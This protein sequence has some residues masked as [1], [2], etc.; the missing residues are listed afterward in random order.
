MKKLSFLGIALL[1]VVMLV[2]SCKKDENSGPPTINF[3]GGEGYIDTDQVIETGTTFKVGIAASANIESN[4]KLSTLRVTRSM[5]GST[6]IDTTLTINET[7]YNVDFEFNSQQAGVVE[8]IDFIV[9]DKAGETASKTLTLTYETFGIP[10]F[11]DLGVTMG[12]HN[13]DNG[14]FYS[15]VTTAVY[16]IAGATAAQD[17]IDFCFYLGATNGSTIASPADPDALTV[18]DIT[19]WT[20]KNATLFTK[21]DMTSEEFDAIGDTFVFPE[22]TNESSA[23]TQLQTNDVIMFQTVNEFPGL[24][25]VNSINGRGDFVSLDIIVTGVAK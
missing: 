14:S 21:L 23:I 12:S 1:S 8:T 10:V 6:F 2:S 15:T 9:T 18:Y 24:I 7:Q 20:T 5:N 4:E 11:K 16:D 25:K 22:L 17:L 3:I 13:D 19:G